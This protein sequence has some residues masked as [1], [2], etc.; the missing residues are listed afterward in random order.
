MRRLTALSMLVASLSLAASAGAGGWAS[1]QL[2]ATPVG[3]SSGDTWNAQFTVLRHGVTPTDGAAPS[4]TISNAATGAAQSFPAEPTGKAGVY[5]A[6]VVFPESG[7]WRYSIDD[8]LVA[9]GYGVSQTTEY[10]PVAVSGPSGSSGGVSFPVA[11]V[12]ALLA[13]AAAFCAVVYAAVRRQRRLT[14]A[15]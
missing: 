11:P 10:P 13:A 15:S 12:L 14:P 1:V 4:V 9:T 8:G 3:L 5:R 7:E 6:A 2:E